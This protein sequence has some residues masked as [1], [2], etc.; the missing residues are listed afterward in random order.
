MYK[1]QMRIYTE[2]GIRVYFV[3]SQ[4]AKKKADLARYKFVVFCK[5][6]KLL[7]KKCF[8][9]FEFTTQITFRYE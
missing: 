5:F 9:G 3:P 4:I 2:A 6:Y 7:L 8:Y 1:K